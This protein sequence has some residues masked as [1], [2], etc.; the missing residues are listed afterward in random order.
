MERD[1]PPLRLTIPNDLRLLPI[2]R[3]FIAGVCQA[4]S[5]D[6]DDT[7]AAVLATHEAA[8]NILR[9]AYRNLPKA[10]LQIE[11]WIEPGQV[12]IRLLDEGE[13]FDVAEVPHFNP[14]EIRL[15][16]R[17]VFLMRA[18]MDELD[19]YPRPER[20]NALRMVKRCRRLPS[21]PLAERA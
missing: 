8:S 21:A 2:V 18:L 7:D 5:L 9:H 13:R 1:N 12:E 15:G 10:V 17:G 4:G 14:A 6:R 20:G 19:C 3:A 11:C 16:G